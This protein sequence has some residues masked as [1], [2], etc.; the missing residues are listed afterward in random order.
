MEIGDTLDRYRVFRKNCVFSQFTATPPSPTS[1]QSSQ[2]NARVQSLLLT[3]NYLYN[4]YQP[5]ACEGSEAN[6]R[7]Y[8]EKNTIFDEHPVPEIG[9]ICKQIKSQLILIKFT[10]KSFV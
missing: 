5:S 6:S 8:L 4:Q 2:S 10:S 9:I 1:L 7:E 3:G